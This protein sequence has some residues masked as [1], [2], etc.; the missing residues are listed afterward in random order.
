MLLF[1]VHGLVQVPADP[2]YFPRI[3]SLIIHLNSKSGFFLAITSSGS[4]TAADEL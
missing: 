4:K 1:F 2:D 3:T